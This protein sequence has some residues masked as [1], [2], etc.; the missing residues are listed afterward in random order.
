M[1]LG[2]RFRVQGLGSSVGQGSQ[3]S[4][5]GGGGVGVSKLQSPSP[6]LLPFAGLTVSSCIEVPVALN[7]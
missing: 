7:E 6:R 3:G 5:G 4:G 1:N 2:L